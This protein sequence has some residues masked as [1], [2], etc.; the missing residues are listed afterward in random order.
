[1]A[2]IAT[3]TLQI[4]SNNLILQD[5]AVRS[6]LANA[7]SA[8]ST[9]AV[10]DMV[11]KDGQ[12]Y[13]CNTAI[14]TAEAWTAAHWTAVTVGGELATVKDGLDAVTDQ[15]N[16]TLITDTASGAIASFPDG[17]DN[18][19]VKSLTVDIEP[20]Q[21]GSGDPSPDN[22]RAING[23]AYAIVTRCGKNI[24]QMQDATS[25][26]TGSV[27]IDTSGRICEVKSGKTYTVSFNILSSTISGATEGNRLGVY[28][29]NNAAIG[30]FALGVT[31]KQ[32]LT[33]TANQNT[34]IKFW[35]GAIWQS[36]TKVLDNIQVEVASIAT[37]YEPY[38]GQ[39]YTIN[40]NGTR[41]GGAL[42][43]TTGVLTVDRVA[44]TFT[45]GTGL[46]EGTDGNADWLCVKYNGSGASWDTNKRTQNI[47]SYAPFT[48]ANVNGNTHFYT[49]ANVFQLFVP[50][51]KYASL[52]AF[53]SSLG[54]NPLTFTAF[55]STSQ[56]VQLT[57]QD[58]TTV[59]GQ[60][61]IWADT[62]DVE[63]EYRA[64]TKLYIQKVINS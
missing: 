16:A 23:W 12:L 46:V 60:N 26:S 33:F 37:D 48:F 18:V 4:G 40:L 49:T 59:Y 5:A 38:E 50:K 32:T 10:G 9:Y 27:T 57:G 58:I 1:M 36:N 45:D 15:I 42:D 3:N 52:S 63:V 43:V 22:I 13:E 53:T 62:G 55:L 61:N 20:L 54:T 41:Y 19:P 56:T 7:Y 24:S 25:S 29:A 14:S 44:Y 35:S 47:C 31:G 39:T 17:A 21:S 28:Y 2:D 6:S 51:S 64:D 8:S 11:L 34:Y 30:R